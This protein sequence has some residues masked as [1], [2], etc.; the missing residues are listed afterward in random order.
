MLKHLFKTY[1]PAFIILAV[2]TSFTFFAFHQSAVLAENRRARLFE[3]RV[4]QARDAVQKR[5]TDY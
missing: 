3:L 5:L 4:Q 2:L 1:Y